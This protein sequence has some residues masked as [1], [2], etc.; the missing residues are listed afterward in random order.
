MDTGR[1]PTPSATPVAGP[2]AGNNG[3]TGAPTGQPS[4]T[5]Y[6]I[7]MSKFVLPEDNTRILLWRQP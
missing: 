1:A 4:G 6:T 5:S 7:D 2:S 3:P